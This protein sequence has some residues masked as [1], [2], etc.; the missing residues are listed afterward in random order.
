MD[1]KLTRDK[2]KKYEFNPEMIQKE[3]LDMI[4]VSKDNQVAVTN[5]T[6]PFNMLLEATAVTT[7]NA[8]SESI[9]IMRSKYASL[10]TSRNHL[11]H[12]LS[13]DEIE[14]IFSH[15]GTVDM[16]FRVSVTD[17]VS[18]GYRPDKASYVEFTIPEKTA[19]TVYETDFTTLNDIVI[20]LYDNGKPFVEMLPNDNPL[21]IKD[22][23]IIP[24][25]LETT[26]DGHSYIYFETRVKQLTVTEYSYAIIGGEG[27]TKTIKFTHID[28]KFN[29][30][31]VSYN[32][33][34]S[35]TTEVRLPI[36]FNDEYLDPYQ[37]TAY[38]T[39]VDNE[40]TDKLITTAIRI[41]IP[42]TYIIHNKISGTIKIELYETKGGIYL[43][44]TDIPAVEFKFKLGNIGKNIS[45]SVTKN[46]NIL[47][48]SNSVLANGSS[49]LTVEE[50]RNA[51]IFN[52]K[53][54]Q[55]LPIT[56]HQLS[57]NNILNGFEV[58]KDYDILTGRSYVAMKNLN[59]EPSTFLR[60]LQDV[61]FNTVNILLEDFLKHKYVGVRDDTFIIKSN[62][63]FK[64]ING[65]TS[66]VNMDQIEEINKLKSTEKIEYFN[67]SNAKY[68]ITPYYYMISRNN[69]YTSARVY[70]LDRPKLHGMMIVGINKDIGV[71]ANSLVWSVFKH[72][73]S[74][75]VVIR[76]T[77]NE[78][79]T[80]A[81][82]SLKMML[83]IDLVSKNKLYIEGKY[84][85]IE[86]CFRF[87]ID[88]NMY[89]DSEDNI[90]L[91]N[92]KATTVTNFS[93]LI[94]N[95][96]IYTYTTDSTIVDEKH[97]LRGELPTVDEDY[98]VLNK[99]TI[100]LTFGTRLKDIWSKISISY[101][102]RK[103]KT[104]DEDIK[105]VYE[106]DVF[107]IDPKSGSILDIDNKTLKVIPLHR[108]GDPVLDKNGQQ[109]IKHK[110]GDVII[111]TRGL[112]MLNDLGGMIRH[113]DICML[114]Y[115]FYLSTN[116]LYSK[117]IKMSIDQI[118][119]YVNSVLPTRNNKLLENTSLLYKS[120]KTCLPV[121]TRINNI[122]YG[123]DPFVKPN[124]I[125][126][127]NQNINF[128]ISDLDI[129]K[130]K[131]QIGFIIDKYLEK[132][133]IKLSELRSIIMES[134]G[135]DLLSVKITNIDPNNSEIIIIEDKGTRLALA[136]ELVMNN[137]NQL[138]VKYNIG[139]NIQTL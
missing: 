60:S 36:A 94:T 38:V 104:Y 82:D 71:R 103:Y 52:T 49:G 22:I 134:I 114:D 113:I 116:P 120:Y 124:I 44:L 87:F 54:D 61:Y 5:P 88:S 6:S 3:I 30:V 110:K 29:Y 25:V 15:P 132:P 108:K 79:A 67:N 13:D 24:S 65:K 48:G 138:E 72:Y 133:I 75:E 90:M 37:P 34:N 98:V 14:G 111:N 32:N 136:K 58:M 28:N 92:G 97:Y 46:I 123:L 125:L 47:I 20:K 70:D 109:V 1:V 107:D 45:T 83:A 18:H 102:E 126:Y 43:P 23:G 57:Y 80:I 78:E 8:I 100:K 63:I 17:M 91:T 127:Y 66:I 64:S 55:N 10:A 50:L 62:A 122:I 9:D 95:V 118:N 121:K 26:T 4:S 16:V 86:D 129:E 35:N 106:E 68:F 59:K 84:D 2:L 27:F 41:H 40:V 105:A 42:D 137:Y 96:D 117:H 93:K 39:L 21:S 99:E 128:K 74:F 112:P 69:N 56:D 53:G 11:A 130:L 73:D 31:K 115:E 85:S 139:L 81:N 101:T 131:D 33:G 51:I 12:H 89:V 135:N 76:L 7:S 119:E 19:I 77:K